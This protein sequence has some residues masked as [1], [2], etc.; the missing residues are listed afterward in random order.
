MKLLASPQGLDRP[1]K[2][3]LLTAFCALGFGFSAVH[4]ADEEKEPEKKIT[5]DDDILPIFRQRCGSCHNG[6]DQKG[7]LVLDTY[8]GMMQGGGSGNVIEQ[9]DASSSYLYMV[10]THESE[11]VMPPNQPKMPEAE[12]ALIRDWID[13]G[14]LENKGSKV[15]K[16]KNELAKIEIST[17]RPA[18]APVMPPESLTL[19][20]VHVY[21]HANSI[22]ALA[23]SPWA[24]LAAVSGYEQ[25]VLYNTTTGLLA[26][27]LPFPEGVPQI[28]KFS[29]NG[30]L[31][32]AGGGRGGASG[33]VIIFDIKTGN[34]VAE[35]GNEYDSVLAADISSD[36]ALVALSGPKRL[37]RVHSVQ[38]GELLYEKKKHTDWVLAAEFS[39]DGVLLATADRSNGL[40]LWESLTGNEYLS[41]KG[42]SGPI[43]D[44]SWRPDSNMLGSCSEDGTIRLWE[45]NNGNEVKRWNAHGGGVSAMDFTR[46]GNI[47]SIGRDRKVK[48]WQLDGKEIKSFGDFKD[49]GLEV[50]YDAENK[51]A[52]G[53]DWT[54]EVRVWDATTGTQLFTLAPNPAD[55]PQQLSSVT[56]TLA[57]Q[58]KKQEA[59]TKELAALNAKIAARSQAVEAK[60]K[61]I[62]GQEA[63]LK[64]ANEQKA[65]AQKKVETAKSALTKANADVT[66][67]TGVRDQLAKDLAAQQKDAATK[68]DALDKAGVAKQAADKKVAELTAQVQELEKQGESA[69]DALAQAKTALADAQKAAE[70]AAQA[71]TAATQ[72]HQAAIAKVQATQ[73]SQQ[74]NAPALTA[75]QKAAGEQTA[76]VK[77]AEQELNAANAS[78]AKLNQIVPALKKQLAEME[79]A[80]PA[81][82]DEKKKQAELAAGVKQTE[83]TVT[84]LKA[85]HQRVEKQMAGAQQASAN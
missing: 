74:E 11:P 29:R 76:T 47:I 30:Q 12:L 69:K 24:P 33:K 78:I 67:L 50:A 2:H 9:G 22:T 36:H 49:L 68:K 15:V 59:L 63:A 61:E 53:G 26:G 45:L 20:P 51:R 84:A 65:A 42:H 3:L 44:V 48:L 64:T 77:A 14:A 75:A 79:K 1:M 4:A 56:S 70:A 81:T 60:K 31:L 6:N 17:D 43:T 85:H 38:T 37:I 28:L 13:M 57:E 27:V 54:G 19:D 39:P 41:L 72:A 16:K 18:D 73:K 71:V 58:S 7:G 62:A 83:Q 52:L 10:I 80:A 40:E 46:D 5:Y 34:R 25:I 35:V 21:G 55:L 82:E 32:M 23:T 8:V 66:K